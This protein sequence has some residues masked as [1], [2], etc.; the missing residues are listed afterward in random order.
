MTDTWADAN[1]GIN[2]AIISSYLEK[3]PYGSETKTVRRLCSGPETETVGSLPSPRQRFSTAPK[4]PSQQPPSSDGS[5][6]RACEREVPTA[7]ECQDSGTKRA[8]SSASSAL[9]TWSFPNTAR[10]K[11]YMKHNPPYFVSH[12]HTTNEH[13]LHTHTQNYSLHFFI[14]RFAV[15][16]YTNKKDGGS[17][18]LVSITP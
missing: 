2:N 7:S 5:K 1:T 8:R 18:I 9:V 10:N 12:H 3:Q 13:P 11:R 16:F 4:Q 17:S 15:H 6:D 14:W